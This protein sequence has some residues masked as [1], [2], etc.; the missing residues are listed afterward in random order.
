MS[1]ADLTYD[2]SY[3]ATDRLIKPINVMITVVV[4]LNCWTRS[5]WLEW[6]SV[7]YI[8]SNN[9]QNN[10]LIWGRCGG[11][12]RSS[13]DGV[14]W[15]CLSRR[16]TAA[17]RRLQRNSYAACAWA[18]VRSLLIY[19][20]SRTTSLV[21]FR[22]TFALVK[23]TKRLEWNCWWL[24]RSRRQATITVLLVGLC[25][26]LLLG[27]TDYRNR[28]ALMGMWDIRTARCCMGDRQTYKGGIKR[29]HENQIVDESC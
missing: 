22:R 28:K 3:S 1:V 11:T 25:D 17:A 14:G 23:A 21:D 15:E 7:I 24:L 19:I 5:R 18:F 6:P 2:Q 8:S 26:M 12:G 4:K 9:S 27:G 10:A 29:R 13:E 20:W 16:R